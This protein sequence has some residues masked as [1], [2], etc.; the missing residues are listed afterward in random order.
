MNRFFF[1]L[2][3]AALFAACG[4]PAGEE[5]T[6]SDAV[7]E[8]AGSTEMVASAQYTVD[9]AASMI[10]WTGSK[11]VGGGSHTG[12]IPVSDGQL[13]ISEG[14][15]VGGKFTMDVRL[16]KN[17]D[18]P[19]EDAAKLEGHLK[20]GDFFDVEK[21]PMASFDITSIQP[22]TDMEGATHKITGN[23]TLKGESR[24]ITLPANVSMDGEMFKASTPAFTIDRKEWGMTYGSSSI[25]DLAKDKVINDEVGLELMLVAKK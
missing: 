7:D 6:S 23:L 17:A 21:F 25:V 10:T 4:G 22:V 1:L 18:L 15:L 24:S 20:S 19:A 3:F 5:V 16:L 14:N 9:P 11:L 8:A 13:M 12:T 2:V